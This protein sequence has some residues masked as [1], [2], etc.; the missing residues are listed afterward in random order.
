MRYPLDLAAI[1]RPTAGLT[2][3]SKYTLG[4]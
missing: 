3:T 4:T 2:S 1:A